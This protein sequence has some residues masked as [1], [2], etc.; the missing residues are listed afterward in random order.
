MI[1]ID[2]WE[3]KEGEKSQGEISIVG[4]GMSMPATVIAGCRPGPVVLVTAGVHSAE[5]VGM[6]AAMDL[7]QELEPEDIKGT[8]IFVPVVNRCGFEHRTMSMVH[9][10]GKN[11]NRVFPGDP[12]GTIADRIAYTVVIK[13][14]SLADY[15]IDLHSGD[16]YEQLHPY[17]Y[18]VGPVDSKTRDI[19]LEMARHVNVKYIVESKTASGGAYNYAASLGIP[20]ILI[21]RG[22]MGEWSWEEA[23]QDKQDVRRILNYLWGVKSMPG[24]HGKQM[25]LR[26]V[27]YEYAPYTGCWY[28]LKKPGEYFF[29]GEI[30]GELRD[31]YGSLLYVSEADG[32]GLVLYQTASLNILEDGPMITYA[33]LSRKM[34]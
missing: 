19:S 6:Q 15:Y 10:D 24:H 2:N 1:Q 3:I 7:A 23:D 32:D 21:E 25:V 12:E 8:V 13:L 4:G 5:F 26:D 18:Y 33:A 27:I 14:F 22:G 31:Y 11:L 29:D 9:G 34:V 28:P 17:V 20:S 16:G 30:L